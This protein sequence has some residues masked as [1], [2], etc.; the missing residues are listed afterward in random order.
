MP[1]GIGDF[2]GAAR[3]FV[4]GMIE[5]ALEDI[6]QRLNSVVASV[7]A[8]RDRVTRRVEDVLEQAR[9]TYNSIVGAVAR[10]IDDGLSQVRAVVRGVEDA[11]SAR[12]GEGLATAI[13]YLGEGQRKVTETL[14]AE[15]ERVRSAVEDIESTVRAQIRQGLEGVGNTITEV[16]GR[17]TT[18]VG[19]VREAVGRTAAELSGKLEAAGQAVQAALA[20]IGERLGE[21]LTEGA[22][23]LAE[24]VTEAPARFFGFSIAGDWPNFV[25]IVDEIVRLIETDENIP[26]EVKRIFAPGLPQ[27]ALV[28]LGVIVFVVWTVVQQY[29]GAF[30]S[31][32][33]ELVR[34][35][36]LTLSKPTRLPLDI[37]ATLAARGLVEPQVAEAEAGRIGVTADRLWDYVRAIQARLTARDY[38]DAWLRGLLD[39]TEY[40][41]VL[42][43]LGYDLGDVSLIRQLAFVLPP[44]SDLIRMAVREVFTPEVAE[45]FGQFE[46]FPE[47]FARFAKQVGLSEEWARAYWAAHWELPSATMGFEM[48]HR[49]IITEDELKMLLRALDVMPFWRDRLIQLSYNPL[50]RV[51]VRRMYGM[52]VLS[53]EEV[54]RAYLDLGYSPENAERLTEFTVR[55]YEEPD[56][57]QQKE[58]RDLTRSQVVQFYR[59]GLFDRGEAIKALQDIGYDADIADGL[60]AL[61]DLK[62]AQDTQRRQVRI[63]ERQ[64]KA[65]LI[66][67]N[68]AVVKLD[69]LGLSASERDLL[70]SEWEAET[71][72]E[73][74]QPSRADLDRMLKAGIIT[75]DE[76]LDQLRALGYRDP[77]PERYAKLVESEGS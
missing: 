15:T 76:Y 53:R 64:F 4:Q 7:S 34:E 13:R 18:A 68:D 48:F 19:E 25:D 6:R 23:G 50:T 14:R 28:V 32:S 36:A 56:E 11:L 22:R 1:N 49:G 24:A 10:Q 12:V 39:D 59:A 67:Y 58:A 21:R 8:I 73:V 61:E 43:R 69:G 55:L 2:V 52:G 62:Q 30:T 40:Q 33:A 38:T 16:G 72:A 37:I 29:I 41:V 74:R 77:W 9:D 35:R 45:K 66:D 26:P 47:T 31:P 60:L 57:S 3:E 54:K 44:V 65:G 27:A 71:L 75:R 63:V 70:L 42:K 51:D 17:I 46:D 5:R 20:E